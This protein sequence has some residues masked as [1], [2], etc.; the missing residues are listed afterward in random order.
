MK[1]A[2]TL[3]LSGI[4]LVRDTME[5]LIEVGK[6]NKCESTVTSNAA[7]QSVFSE[8]DLMDRVH[9]NSEPSTH[10]RAVHK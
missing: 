10:Q 3:N 8:T 7:H 4:V 2:G 9:S 5:G 1:Q 6:K